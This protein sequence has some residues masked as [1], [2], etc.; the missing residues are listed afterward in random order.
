MVVRPQQTAL[1][2]AGLRVLANTFAAFVKIMTQLHREEYQQ[3]TPYT[4][5]RSTHH[6]RGRPREPARGTTDTA[7]PDAR[8]PVAARRISSHLS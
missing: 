1:S 4:A 5:D 2:R 6:G 7:P 8:T 3:N